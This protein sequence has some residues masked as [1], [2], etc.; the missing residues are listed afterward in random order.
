MDFVAAAEP[1]VEVKSG[2]RQIE[3]QIVLQR[4]ASSLCLKETAAL[5][6][7][8]TGLAHDVA[9]YDGTLRDVASGC[10][11]PMDPTISQLVSAAPCSNGC[12]SGPREVGVGYSSCPV[13][14]RQ[15]ECVAVQAFEATLIYRETRSA[16]EEQSPHS[17]QR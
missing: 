16:F 10:I 15:H 5:L 11:P 4:R 12:A 14:A 8:D 9:S 13:E 1:V 2:S 17:L 3:T 7:P 6:L